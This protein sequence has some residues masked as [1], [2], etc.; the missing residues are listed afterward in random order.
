MLSAL[1][2]LP[3]TY[4]RLLESHVAPPAAIRL[5]I[6]ALHFGTYVGP[7]PVRG[8]GRGPNAIPGRSRV[9]KERADCRADGGHRGGRENSS[10]VNKRCAKASRL[11]R[12]AFATAAIYPQVFAAELLVLIGVH[13]AGW[14][15]PMCSFFTEYRAECP[16]SS[17]QS[18]RMAMKQ[19]SSES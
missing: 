10:T 12:W 2:K 14:R 15:R 7:R 1:R 16:T 17:V 8:L 11:H 18:D 13:F 3:F 6:Y 4:A 5:F 9:P 19:M